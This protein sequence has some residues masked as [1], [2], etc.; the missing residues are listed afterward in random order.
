MSYLKKQAD[1]KAKELDIDIK[2]ESNPRLLALL[3]KPMFLWLSSLISNEKLQITLNKGHT[4]IREF[5]SIEGTNSVGICIT[6]NL[7]KVFHPN[8]SVKMK[9]KDIDNL[10][11]KKESLLDYSRYNEP[12]IITW[13]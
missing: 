8:N 9:F 5:A 1:K 7:N 2:P 10:T 12:I 4:L 6:D 13:K 11:N 3:E